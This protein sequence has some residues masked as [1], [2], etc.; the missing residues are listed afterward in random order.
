MDELKLRLSTKFMRG[1]ITKI[2]SKIIFDKLGY[3]I[4]IQLNEIKIETT[5]GKVHLHADVDGEMDNSEF[6]KLVKSI[7][8]D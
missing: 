2:I 1:I 6:M 4:N 8:I 3:R 7:G 5:D